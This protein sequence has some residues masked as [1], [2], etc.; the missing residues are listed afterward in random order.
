MTEALPMGKHRALPFVGGWG[1]EGNGAV[2][3]VVPRKQRT[4]F[5]GFLER[6]GQHVNRS[7]KTAKDV[8]KCLT[9]RRKERRNQEAD[10]ERI[11]RRR[12]FW[13]YPRF[14]DM[15]EM[16]CQRTRTGC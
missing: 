2:V 3:S 10:L 9:V 11:P 15:L 12:N 4:N 5:H 16:C 7:R 14:P 8:R 6:P 13:Q 1:A